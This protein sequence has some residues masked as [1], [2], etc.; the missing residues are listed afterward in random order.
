MAIIEGI[1]VNSVTEILKKL[2]PFIIK[3]IRLAKGFKTELKNLQETLELILTVIVDA[4]AKQVHENAV[5]FW[6]IRLKDVAYEADDV[7][8]DF[9]YELMRRQNETIGK[10]DK[11]KLLPAGT[12]STAHRQNSERRKRETS[13][14]VND[15][16]VIRRKN[17]QSRIIDLLINS[18]SWSNE[19][20]STVSI[21][22]TGGLG[23][24]TLAQQVFDDPLIK[25]QFE[26]RIWVYVSDSDADTFDANKLLRVIL[27][28]IIKHTCDDV[29]NFNE[30]VCQVHLFLSGKKYLL[31]LDDL[32]SENVHQWGRLKSLLS[33]GAHES[34]ILV[35]TRKSQ[36]ASIV[37]GAISPYTLQHLSNE[38]CWCIIK[39]KAFAPGG[40]LESD[41]DMSD[42]GRT[43]AKQCCG[44]PLVA[45]TLGGLM[46]LKNTESDWV[47]ITEDARGNLKSC[48]T[49]DLLYDLA[50]SVG[51]HECSLSLVKDIQMK[52]VSEVRRLGLVYEEEHL[53]TF[54]E[55]LYAAKKVRTFI[56]FE[57][58]HKDIKLI[59]M[60]SH[61]RVL[62]MTGLTISK[63]LITSIA[64]LRH[65][66]YLNLSFPKDC[67]IK[68]IHCRSIGALPSDI[69]F[70]KNL[71]HLYL[72]N[73][74]IQEL[75][76]SISSLSNL[77][78][79]NLSCCFNLQ[80][81]HEHVG[82]LTDLRF[83]NLS[84][85][86]VKCLPESI[87][88][89]S[90]L[91]KL[92]LHNCNH[93][94]ELPRDLGALRRLVL[95]D[96]SFTRIKEL[97]ESITVC[98]NL[99]SLDFRSC[100]E[101]D[102]LPRNIGVALKHERILD[103][104]DT[105][106]KELPELRDLNNLEYLDLK[107]CVLPEDIGNWINLEHVKYRGHREETP[108][109]L[110]RMAKLRT[111]PEYIIREGAEIGVLKGLNLLE[112][113]FQI[114][115][116]KNV[117]GGTEEVL[118]ANLMEKRNVRHLGL[119]WSCRGFGD[120][121]D[122]EEQEQEEEY[123]YHSPELVL[124]G[125]QPHRNLK[126]LTID[127]FKCAKLPSWMEMTNISASLPNLTEIQLRNCNRNEQI[128]GFMQIPHLKK[129]ILCKLPELKE[130]AESL[131]AATSSSNNSNSH[132]FPCL[133]E[134]FIKLCPKLCRLPTLSFPS[135][136][137]F[138]VKLSNAMV[139]SSILPN[140]TSPY[141]LKMNG[142]L[143]LEY[144]PRQTLQPAL[145]YLEIWGCPKFGGFH[146]AEENNIYAAPNCSV[147]E[148]SVS[149]RELHIQCPEEWNSLSVDLER[150]TDLEMIRIG[151]FSKA[152]GLFPFSA[153]QFSSFP[154]LWIFEID[155]CSQC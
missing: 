155:G 82:A 20:L 112:G 119:N 23:K 71:R 44:L 63:S 75:P 140:L 80:E 132:L 39:Q 52:D 110:G 25:A 12:F 6:L 149:L 18:S 109:G 123:N 65:L 126:S 37:R 105:M 28:S 66:R 102:A 95:L 17:D 2:I 13:S 99:R 45:K 133:E 34:K 58:S 81:M 134:L 90:N 89:C 30:L 74:K 86:L 62:D 50:I 121:D 146:P 154:S 38:D 101:L 19:N 97:P 41:P 27:E 131:S 35:T 5:S 49:H 94:E 129:L 98:T 83:L 15:L 92:K 70:L 60:N 127:G 88:F 3:N 124:E 122:K 72:K 103:F 46:H 137:N 120:T 51:K 151:W 64:R 136:K 14:Y 79:L 150:V 106:I 100:M 22:G 117:R 142:I 144:L 128:V 135:L 31:V 68:V 152:P 69:G 113:T 33:V 111:L 78:T 26:P 77:Q 93:F 7:L 87:T 10:L 67:H 147:I 48:K 54:R 61:L 84:R 116:L 53:S 125:L 85:T 153:E 55:L 8:D 76:K 73:S 148:E 96:V 4:E 21:V 138:E 16:E 56:L 11:S 32:W 57:Q 141:V 107:D 143:D 104:S 36:V 59:C 118:S 47:S 40:A 9:A 115:N 43:I 130:W 29:P 114:Y 42:I 24:T 91:E 1:L 108:R 145:K 139:L